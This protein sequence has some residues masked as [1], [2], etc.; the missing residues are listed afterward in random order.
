MSGKKISI[1]CNNVN[2]YFQL[3]DSLNTDNYHLLFFDKTNHSLLGEEFL[4]FFYWGKKAWFANNSPDNLNEEKLWNLFVVE[5]KQIKI[6]KMIL[7]RWVECVILPQ[8]QQTTK[9]KYMWCG[10]DRI[11][12]FVV[13]F[14]FFLFLNFIFR[15][16]PFYNQ[17]HIWSHQ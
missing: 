16:C 9:H 12:R 2:P 5:W 15:A 17:L 8:Q 13:K 11:G 10:G 3:I 1:L 6:I 4:A 7:W 14:L